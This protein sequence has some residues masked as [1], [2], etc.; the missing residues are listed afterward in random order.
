MPLIAVRAV[1][2]AALLFGTL[3]TPCYSRLNPDLASLNIVVNL[4]SR[5]LELYSGADFVKAYP[6]AIGKPSTPSPLGQFSIFEKEVNPA[7]YP[8]RTG[9]IVPSGPH[10]PLG[11]RWMGFASLYG[12][13]GTNAPWAIGM[14][15]SNGCIRMYEKDVEEL[16]EVVPCGTPVRITYDR[17]KARIDPDG[18]ASIGI[19]PDI[20]SYQ[21]VSLQEAKAKLAALGLNG[22]LEDGEI[23]RLIEEE[24]DTQVPFASLH[25]VK[26]NGKPLVER[27][28]TSQGVLYVP[29]WPVAAALQASLTWD[30]AG[31]TV[32]GEKQS[33]PGLIK[34]DRLYVTAENARLLFGGQQAW[35]PEENTLAIDGAA[36][37]LNG[38]PIPGDV[39][40]VDGILAVPVQALAD[41]LG[42]KVTRDADGAFYV[43]GA[44]V[45]C[46]LIGGSPYI[47]LTKVYDV[48]QAYVYWNQEG[49]CVEITYPFHV[50]GGND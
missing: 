21:G 18:R 28:I 46:R 19:Y 11:Y 7:W 41:A 12:I 2:L 32:K 40:A 38:R 35:Q 39:Q 10:N 15:V 9:E 6:I 16:F 3:V 23:S 34:G 44:K 17:V 1:L 27:A 43:Q 20:Y 50:T 47:Q 22:W 13:H 26:V 8:P 42:Q 5:T 36:L 30:E 37:F 24:A 31:R 25:T 45:P 14:A 49:R 4:P 48:F 29:V 33:V